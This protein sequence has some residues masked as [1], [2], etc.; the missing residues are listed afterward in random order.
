MSY[1]TR[2]LWSAVL[3][4]WGWGSA[5]GQIQKY[6]WLKWRNVE[7]ECHRFLSFRKSTDNIV[8]DNT[9]PVLEVKRSR[10]VCWRRDGVEGWWDVIL[11]GSKVCCE[12]ISFWG[13]LFPVSR[14]C[15]PSSWVDSSPGCSSRCFG[16]RSC[17]TVVA[18]TEWWTCHRKFFVYSQQVC[19]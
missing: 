14:R 17:C 6:V 5:C 2:R 10:T 9:T 3:G 8:H 13:E 1:I 15:W 19:F 16:S 11:T 4:G 7:N 12:V 18:G